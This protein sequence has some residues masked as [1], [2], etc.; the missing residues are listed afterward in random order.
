MT[1]IEQTLDPTNQE[2]LSCWKDP[3][4]L[5]YVPRR[6]SIINVSDLSRYYRKSAQQRIDSNSLAYGRPYGLYS[7]KSSSPPTHPH[8]LKPNNTLLLL[9][10][11]LSNKN[12]STKWK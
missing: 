8:S 12:L 1:N 2:I 10:R 6:N 11:F 9:P 7:M 4:S 5:Q 3:T